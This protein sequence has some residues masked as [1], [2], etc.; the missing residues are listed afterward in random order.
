MLKKIEFNFLTLLGMVA[1]SLL[2]SFSVTSDWEL[3]MDKDKIKVYTRY[4]EGSKLKEYKATAQINVT[5]QAMIDLLKDGDSLKNW[6][7]G[8]SESRLV[9]KVSEN[10]LFVYSKTSAPWP[11]K[12]RDYVMLV[13]FKQQPDGSILVSLDGKPDYIPVNSCCVRLPYLKGHWQ[14]TSIDDHTTQITHQMHANPGGNIPAWLANSSV[15]DIPFYTF[16]N[17]QERFN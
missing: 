6:L 10:E 17:L 3:A 16:K 2:C 14:L 13:K 9:K 1:F 8:C 12:D 4:V 15:V 5:P 7:A 11:I